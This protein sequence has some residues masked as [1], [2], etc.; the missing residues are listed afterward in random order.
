MATYKYSFQGYDKTNM[1]RASGTNLK[2]SL[3]KTVEVCKAINGKRINTTIDFLE[4]VINQ[5]SVVPYTRYKKEVA[6]K[7]GKGID[8]GGYPKNVATELLKLIKSA[9]KNAQER[10]LGENLYIASASCRKGVRRYRFGRFMGRKMKST[11]VEIILIAKE[12]NK[13]TLRKNMKK[14]KTLEVENK[15]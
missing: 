14:K 9:Q 4:K 15:K 12:N 1:A 7:R 6:H 11:N 8:T 3:K 10:E 13:N 2:I 5:K